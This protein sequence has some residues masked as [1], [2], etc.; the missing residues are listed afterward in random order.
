MIWGDEMLNLDD[1]DRVAAL[2]L[3]T[4]ICTIAIYG[5]IIYVAWHFISKWW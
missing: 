2:G 1:L 5:G 3:L 4:I